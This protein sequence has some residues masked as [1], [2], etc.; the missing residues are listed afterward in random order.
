CAGVA[1]H[2]GEDCWV[3]GDLE[4]GL[5][6]RYLRSVL[7]IGFLKAVALE[8]TPALIAK[9]LVF[10]QTRKAGFGQLGTGHEDA[11]GVA[12][13]QPAHPAKAEALGRRKLEA[14]SDAAGSAPRRN[15]RARRCR[16][17]A[18]GA[19]GRT[20]SRIAHG[21]SIRGRSRSPRDIPARS[22]QAARPAR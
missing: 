14:E 1:A 10:P 2:R 17:S 3:L 8:R 15:V 11:V 19:L 18:R 7:W 21:A 9:A 13:K 12:A 5:I 20:S 16:G 22:F 6:Q 4:V